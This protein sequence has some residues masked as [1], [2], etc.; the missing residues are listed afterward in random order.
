MST[1]I[2]VV[3]LKKRLDA[4]ETIN[5]IDVREQY[6]YDEFNLGGDL[7]PLGTLPGKLEDLEDLKN[8]E[9]IVHCRSGARSGT[10][11]MFLTQS[12]FTNVR[13][14]LGGVLDWQAQF[15]Q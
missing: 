10:A 8:E 3:E 15:G 2:S 5:L 4:G 12:G 11:K 7:I 13:N 1:D 14:L 9:V 6:E